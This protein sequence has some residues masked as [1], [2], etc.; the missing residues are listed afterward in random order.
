MRIIHAG[1]DHLITHHQC[2][3]NVVPDLFAGDV[4]V[5]GIRVDRCVGS[6]APRLAI[7][8]ELHKRIFTVVNDRVGRNRDG[9]TIDGIQRV[10][11]AAGLSAR[12]LLD[13]HMG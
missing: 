3:A 13:L 12:H 4:V 7:R 6:I 2:S 9:D 1:L 8:P 5:P 10:Q 11:A